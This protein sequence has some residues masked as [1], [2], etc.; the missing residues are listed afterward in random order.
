MYREKK[1]NA[2]YE[3]RIELSEKISKDLKKRSLSS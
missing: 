1:P 2:Y 3:S